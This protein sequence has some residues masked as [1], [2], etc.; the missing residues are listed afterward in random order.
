MPPTSRNLFTEI[1]KSA[2]KIRKKKDLNP[3]GG[4]QNTSTQN[5]Y[6]CGSQPLS[7]AV[8]ANRLCYV[9]IDG[10]TS[11]SVMP[12]TSRNLFTEITKSAFKIRKKKI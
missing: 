11:G 3:R 12:P 5:Y 8:L 2:F 9:P 4:L 10:Y 6:T 7:T 1:T